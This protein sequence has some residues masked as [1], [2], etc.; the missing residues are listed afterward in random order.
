MHVEGQ[1][2]L[3]RGY[4]AVRMRILSSFLSK[5]RKMAATQR[6]EQE[7]KQKSADALKK[8]TDPMEIL[9]LKCL[10]RGASGIKGIGRCCVLSLVL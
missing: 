7:L 3:G 9:R 8:A 5:C 6:H 1:R 2:L 10:S 4:L